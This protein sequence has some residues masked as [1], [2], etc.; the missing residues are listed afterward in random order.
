M[1]KDVIVEDAIE[2]IDETP[3][4]AEEDKHTEKMFNQSE[5]DSI[6]KQRVQRESIST[7][8]ARATLE[9]YKKEAESKISAYESVL[10][11]LIANQIE[12]LPANIKSLLSKLD[13][14]EQV[15]WL[16][17]ADNQIEKREIPETPKGNIPSKPKV[18]AVGK[19]F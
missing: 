8:E 15:E 4:P 17:S 7:K 16:S 14:L 10:G 18:S 13:V 3:I 5:L 6:I 9:E 19:L 1:P 11:K 12:P 2:P